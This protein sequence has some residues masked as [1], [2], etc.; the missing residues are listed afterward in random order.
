VDEIIDEIIALIPDDKP[1]REK[2]ADVMQ[3]IEN[4]IRMK[5]SSDREHAKS[6]MKAMKHLGA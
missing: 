6:V 2:V 3:K 5:E 1:T 4:K